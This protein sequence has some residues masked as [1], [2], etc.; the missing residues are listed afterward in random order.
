M[1]NYR[2]VFIKGGCYFFTVITYE[3]RP[4]LTEESNFHRLREAFRRVKAAHPFRIDAIAVLP[5]HLHVIWTLPAGD[6]EFPLRWRKI[7]HFFSVGVTAPDTISSSLVSKREKGVWQRR[8]W[9]HALRDEPD[10]K[11]HIDYI[12]YNPV[13]HGYVER[14]SDW[15]YGS[16]ARAMKQGWY[17]IGWGDRMPESIAD[18]E[19][20]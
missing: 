10:W 5:D 9:E 16:F 13:K 6:D 7:K 12:H 14:P 19:L 1:A 15:Q 11:R 2:R 4:I 18:M 20:E 3:R 17:P 8:Y